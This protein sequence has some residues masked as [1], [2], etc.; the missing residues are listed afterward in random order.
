MKQNL[1]P[2]VAFSA[3]MLAATSASA[4]TVIYSNDYESQTVGAKGSDKTWRT[5]YWTDG[6]GSGQL[7]TLTVEEDAVHGKYVKCTTRAS[8]KGCDAIL[9][10]FRDVASTTDPLS[11]EANNIQKYSIEFDAAFNTTAAII[12]KGGNLTLRGAT[13]EIAILNSASTLPSKRYDNGVCYEGNNSG[14]ADNEWQNIIYWKQD[15]SQ[16]IT[17]EEEAAD[18]AADFSFM[19]MDTEGQPKISFPVDGT[20]NHFKFDV[21]R[22][23]YTVAWTITTAAG[24]AITGKLDS[25]LADN[26][27]LFAICLRTSNGDSSRDYV[28][29]DNLKVTN[30]DGA[31]GISEVNATEN[32]ADN[33]YYTLSGIQTAKPQHGIYIHNGKKM[34]IK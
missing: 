10:R 4:Q 3:M 25:P 2:L 11:I 6:Y 1:L 31:S 22:T 28:A 26:L 18:Y 29:V 7:G 17:A 13:A 34:V 19:D 24:E 21:D 20:W 27:V 12:N 15:G 8:N 30:N 5:T 9:C 23:A 14:P 16:E 32:V 33:A